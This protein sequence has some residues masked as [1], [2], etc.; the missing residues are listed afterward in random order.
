MGLLLVLLLLLPVVELVVLIQVAGEIGFLDTVGLLV[1]VSLVGA[2]LAKR[3]G[4][5]AIRRIQRATAA[6]QT[7]DREVV[8]GALILLAG[9]LLILPGFVS[10][11]MGIA[12]LIPP[13]RAAVRTLVVR[14]LARRQRVVIVGGRSRATAPQPDVWDVESWEDEPSSSRRQIGGD[15]S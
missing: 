13:V 15:Q 1:V 2:W 11:A 10:D 12:L 6:G 4:A 8:D 3:A 9:V 7:P 14:R 5:G